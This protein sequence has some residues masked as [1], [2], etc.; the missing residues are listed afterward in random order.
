MARE[1][2]EQERCTGVL[3]VAGKAEGR[4]GVLR[5]W[6][7]QDGICMV[8]ELHIIEMGTLSQEAYQQSIASWTIQRTWVSL[9]KVEMLL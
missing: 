2:R 5:Y 7:L 8:K 6:G 4:R 3:R 9:L 1:G